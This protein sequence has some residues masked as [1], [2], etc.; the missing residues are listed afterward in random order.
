MNYDFYVVGVYKYREDTSFS[1]EAEEDVVTMVYIP[2]TTG[3][4]MMHSA[5]GPS[6]RPKII[7]DIPPIRQSIIDSTIN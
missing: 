5:N 1:Q 4:E 3:K 7:P 6:N 2:V